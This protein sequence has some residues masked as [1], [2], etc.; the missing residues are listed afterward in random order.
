M[1][2]HTTMSGVV[3][4]TQLAFSPPYTSAELEI[5]AFLRYQLR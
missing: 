1:G 4:I 2:K 5:D 3:K